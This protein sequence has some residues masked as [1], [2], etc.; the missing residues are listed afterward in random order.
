MSTTGESTHDYRIARPTL[1]VLLGDMR[2]PRSDPGPGDRVPS[3]VLPT[4]RGGRF[5]SDSIAE[6]GRPVLLVFGSLTCPI[7]ESAGPGLRRLHTRFGKFARFVLVTVREAHPGSLVG[8]PHT[9]EEKLRNARA[10]EAHHGF[11]FETAVDDIDGSLHRAFGTRPS[12]AY[13]I[14]RTGHILFRA[15]WSNATDALAEALTAAVD[16]RAPPRPT[17]G[18]TLSSMMRMTGYADDAFASAGRGALRD[19]WRAAPPFAVMIVTSRLFRFLP[20]GRRGIPTVLTLTVA[21]VVIGI[22]LA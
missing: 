15:H 18:R 3:F 7:T 10:L 20:R 14:D 4:T 19:T 9:I 22:A 11:V 1:P 13:L 8:Q 21:A 5:S 12:S 17:A 16:H 6:D 2:I